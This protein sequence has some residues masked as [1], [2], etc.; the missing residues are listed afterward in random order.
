M[1]GLAVALLTYSTK[2]RGGVVHTV[3]VA[4]ALAERGHTV[5]VFAIGPS[6]ARFFRR[7]RVPARV[8]PYEGPERPIEAKV[9]AMIEAY[10]AH[11]TAVVHRFDVVHAEDCL[12]ASALAAVSARV[13]L[14]PFLRTVHHLDDFSSPALID[15]QRRSVAAP[16]RLLVVSRYWRDRLR[17]E[18]GVEADVVPNGV[19]LE[20]FR[21]PEG[22][23]RAAARRRFGFGPRPVLLTVG[24][25]EP[26]KGSIRLL[27]A[28]AVARVSLRS[29]RPALVIA[30]GET[31]FDYLDYRARFFARLD[32]LRLA[33]G[34]DVLILGPTDDTA[35]PDLY[36]AADAFVLA[37]TTEG[38]GLAALE[39]QA[40]GLP[41]VLSDLEVFHELAVDGK[42][43]LIAPG[44]NPAA[45]G[46][47]IARAIV[48]EAVR[49]R[50]RAGGRAAAARFGWEASAVAHERVYRETLLA[51]RGGRRGAAEA[52]GA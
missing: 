41:T 26:R 28:F 8:F 39:A 14:P 44:D 50:L 5:E 21:P 34:E 12:S 32:E 37:S 23:E 7:P 46:Q 42:N 38:F 19:D 9:L 2:A 16:D 22:Q 18:L 6:G 47:A 15:C 29:P 1:S 33:L 3:A 30:G 45:L 35:M 25:I 31:L 27:E 13:P 24:G 48:D 20:R 36:R 52:A 43:A 40:S 10:A 17:R 4:E 11:L 51:G 49:E